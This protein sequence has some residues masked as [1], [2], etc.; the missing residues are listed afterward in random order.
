VIQ[1]RPDLAGLAGAVPAASLEW[2]GVGCSYN[3]PAGPKEVLADVWGVAPSGEMQ[4]LLGPSGAGKSTLMVRSR[5]GPG[6]RGRRQ[7][8]RGRAQ[9]QAVWHRTP[10]ARLPTPHPAHPA[11]PGPTTPRTSSRCARAWAT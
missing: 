6:Q 11:R 4:A 9:A 8:M 7:S 1:S 3:T 2:R 10:S 5:L